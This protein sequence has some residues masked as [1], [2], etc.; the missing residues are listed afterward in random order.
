VIGGGLFA[1]D[2]GMALILYGEMGIWADTIDQASGGSTPAV[3]RGIEFD[4][5]DLER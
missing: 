2:L 4:Q 3:T 5:F 1:I